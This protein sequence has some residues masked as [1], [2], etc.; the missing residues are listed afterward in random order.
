MFLREYE[1]TFILR[2]DMPP[3][4]LDATVDK[5]RD[6]IGAH[7][8]KLIELNHWGK[9]KLAYEI[10]KQSRGI[11]FHGLYLGEGA[12]V[13][14]LE[15][16]LRLSDACMRYMTVLLSDRVNPDDRD[17]KEFVRPEYELDSDDDDEDEVEVDDDDRESRFGDSKDGDRYSSGDR[18]GVKAAGRSDDK[19]EAADDTEEPDDDN[20]DDNDDNKDEE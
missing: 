17:V 15:R 9:K 5:V 7:G 6:I 14:E 4:M 11:Y 19:D 13:H 12:T 10:A 1:T 3:T 16:E 2:P 18:G 20:D 8:G